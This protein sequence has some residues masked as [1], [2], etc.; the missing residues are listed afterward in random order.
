MLHGITISTDA[1]YTHELHDQY[2]E[3]EYSSAAHDVQA[4]SDIMNYIEKSSASSKVLSKTIKWSRIFTSIFLYVLIPTYLSCSP[5]G[6]YNINLTRKC[7]DIARSVS[8]LHSMFPGN[9]SL[10]DRCKRYAVTSSILGSKDRSRRVAIDTV[11]GDVHILQRYHDEIFPADL[12]P[13]YMNIIDGFRLSQLE[14]ALLDVIECLHQVDTPAAKAYLG[15]REIGVI[16]DLYNRVVRSPD[17][18]IDIDTVHCLSKHPAF[19]MSLIRLFTKYLPN[20]PTIDLDKRILGASSSSTSTSK[21]LLTPY[22]YREFDRL[23]KQRQKIMEPESFLEKARIRKRKRGQRLREQEQQLRES[24]RQAFDRSVQRYRQ[25]QRQL[26]EIGRHPSVLN[27]QSPFGLTFDPAN[28]IPGTRPQQDSGPVSNMPNPIKPA[29]VGALRSTTHGHEQLLRYDSH[30]QASIGPIIDTFSPDGV[31]QAPHEN[32]FDSTGIELVQHPQENKRYNYFTE[33]ETEDGQRGSLN[34]PS[35]CNLQSFGA[36][37]GE[38][39]GDLTSY[40]SQFDETEVV[41]RA[42]K[43]QSPK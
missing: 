21:R 36:D 37:A 20:A 3:S 8:R 39:F 41:V 32:R 27:V 5:S 30:R 6:R 4:R 14:P 11:V 25:H 10:E 38:S 42:F 29:F 17:T 24:Q 16:I 28:S 22:K 7:I 34:S 9:M 35:I 26:S 31:S 33:T 15:N 40:S 18:K 13:L 43:D 23:Q 19:G 1:P 2:S 12:G